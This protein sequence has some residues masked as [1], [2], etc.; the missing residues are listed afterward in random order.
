LHGQSFEIERGSDDSF[1][2]KDFQLDRINALKED[3]KKNNWNG[4]MF[5]S[6]LE[7]E[8]EIVA[9]HG[10]ESYKIARINAE[11]ASFISNKPIEINGKL[12]STA[13]IRDV[14]PMLDEI[15]SKLVLAPED[16]RTKTRRVKAT[17]SITSNLSDAEKYRLYD[18]N[19]GAYLDGKQR[20]NIVDTKQ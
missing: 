1:I 16:S 15:L 20:N 11:G 5:H 19:T 4:V 13:V 8:S 6:S 17:S 3:A 7:K 12:D 9:S 2:Y 18:E 14:E 10:S